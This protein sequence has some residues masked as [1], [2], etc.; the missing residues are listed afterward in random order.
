VHTSK[1]KI[2]AKRLM[3]DI[4]DTFYEP[5]LLEI[6]EFSN[7]SL[8]GSNQCL[9]GKVHFGWI[10]PKFGW[11]KKVWLESNQC[12]VGTIYFDWIKFDWE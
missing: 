7:Q 1:P 4:I 10:Q 9:V 3:H 6:F 2:E 11:D 8:I 12:L 5:S